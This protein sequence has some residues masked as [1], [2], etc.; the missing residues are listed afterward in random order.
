MKMKRFVMISNLLQDMSGPFSIDLTTVP[1][2]KLTSILKIMAQPLEYPG[3]I[4]DLRVE[5]CGQ[6]GK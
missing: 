2:D 1:Q 5:Y 6:E 4:S 3:T